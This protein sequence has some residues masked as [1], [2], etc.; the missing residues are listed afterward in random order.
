MTPRLIDLFKW[1]GLHA[2]WKDRLLSASLV[3]AM[4]GWGLYV[5]ELLTCS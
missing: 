5:V 2:S 4:L 1:P 3:A